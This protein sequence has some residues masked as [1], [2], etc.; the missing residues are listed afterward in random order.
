MTLPAVP[1]IKVLDGVDQSGLDQLSVDVAEAATAAQP[2]KDLYSGRDRGARV[3]EVIQIPYNPTA[4]ASNLEVP[5]LSGIVERVCQ[6]GA[7]D[8]IEVENACVAL[9]LGHLMLTGPPGT[10]KTRLARELTTEFRVDPIFETANAE[11]SVY[12]VIGSQTLAGGGLTQPKHG[13]VTRAIIHCYTTMEAHAANSELPQ[14]AWLVIDELNRAEIDRAFGPLF[15]ALSGESSAEFTLDYIPGN[16]K[17]VIPSRFRIIATLNSFDTRFVNSMSAALRRRFARAL[18][19]PPANE[20]S[21]VPEHEFQVVMDTVETRLSQ[22]RERKPVGEIMNLLQK[23][24]S[25]VRQVFGFIREPVDKDGIRRG[26]GI[27]IGTAHLI[28]SCLFTAILMELAQGSDG[29]VAFPPVFDR[30]LSAQLSNSFE[31]DNL[32]DRI[33]RD[34]VEMFGA[35]YQSF[36]RI[37]SRF[38]AFLRGRE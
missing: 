13:V 33:T 15:T 14:A 4:A 27:P 18:I 1:K 2:A 10:G 7:Y 29:Q 17:I 8:P 31:S 19:L 12:D 5:G 3:A 21:L 20:G 24:A 37:R 11:W 9:T 30:A 23:N 6:R 26:E 28:D 16:H 38:E 25:L 35:K 36:S 34:F 32:R 22:I